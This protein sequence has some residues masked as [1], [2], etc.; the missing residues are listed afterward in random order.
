MNNVYIN[1]Y[2]YMMKKIL[3]FIVLFT[4]PLKVMAI[5]AKSAIVLDEESGNILYAKDIHNQMLIA[6]ITKIMTCII[7]IENGNLNDT[8][9]ADD[10]ILRVT[11]SS[12]YIEVGESISLKDLL[13]GMMMRSGNDAAYL[14]A[15]HISGSMDGFAS[16][17]NDYA[18]KIG[19]NN[20]IFINSHGLEEENAEN[21]S[22]AYDMALLTRYAMQN[23]TFREI[24]KSKKYTAKSDK[25]TYHF[26]NKNKLLKYDYITGG[27]TGYTKKAKRTL[28]S[29]A[30]INNMNLI[31]VTLNDP[32]DW[33]DHIDLYNMIKNTYENKIVIKKNNFFIYDDTVFIEDKLYIKDSI[34]LIVKKGSN[35]IKIK[36]Y[37]NSNNNYKDGDIV[38]Y[39]HIYNENKLIKKCP[40]Y[41]KKGNFKIKNRL[42]LFFHKL[43][44]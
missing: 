17:M 40:I 36:Y 25:K 14:I 44:N 18:K 5:S 22:T 34:S 27:K 38:G 3:L 42:K 8:I 39:T 2:I 31:I 23:D 41:I 29:T 12:I 43:F 28:V 32:N 30:S 13:Y 19:M 11:G 26:I 9:K 10:G 37:L 7:A 16:L 4:F 33:S 6:S 21:K 20:T 24:F 1:E 15:K 35:D